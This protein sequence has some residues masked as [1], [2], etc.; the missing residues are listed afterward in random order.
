MEFGVEARILDFIFLQIL[1]TR[2]MENQKIKHAV[3]VNRQKISL[4]ATS[5]IKYTN[6]KFVKAY[7]PRRNTCLYA[8]VGAIATVILQ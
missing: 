1:R 2:D 7:S 6:Y 4:S 8:R 3:C 5:V